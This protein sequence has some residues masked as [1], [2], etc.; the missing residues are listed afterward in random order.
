MTSTLYH[1]ET[2]YPGQHWI[3]RLW[4][5]CSAHRLGGTFVDCWSERWFSETSTFSDSGARFVLL[6]LRGQSESCL[7]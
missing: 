3:I 7:Q 5:H 6:P 1:Y 2:M 4:L